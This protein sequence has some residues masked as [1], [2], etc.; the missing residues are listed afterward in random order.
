MSFLL[1][2]VCDGVGVNVAVAVGDPVGVDVDVDVDGAVDVAV[3]PSAGR[4]WPI[5][6][7]RSS[8]AHHHP[9]R[10]RLLF[11]SHRQSHQ[12]C[13]PNQAQQRQLFT[14]TC[15]GLRCRV[16]DFASSLLR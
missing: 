10:A 6:L 14:T 8:P 12:G 11:T 13:G 15:V 16:F 2:L 3:V 9:S 7:V 1:W 4:C 5:P